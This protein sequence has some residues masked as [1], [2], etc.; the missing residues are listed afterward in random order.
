MTSPSANAAFRRM[1]DMYFADVLA[2]CLRRAST[3]DAK[4]AVADVFL[5]A[6][7]RFDDM[8]NGERVLPWLYGTARRVLANQRRSRSRFARLTDR[9]RSTA[10]EP[11]HVPTPETI[12]VRNQRSQEV[13]DALEHLRPDDR[14]VV[15]LVMWE[16]LPHAAVGEVL[17]CSDRAVTMRLHRAV[18][19]LRSELHTSDNGSLDVSSGTEAADE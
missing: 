7:R 1:Y 6:W 16:G 11:E 18:G 3:E 8:P 13:L 19:R 9:L 15:R 4:D 14:E 2:Y 5:V 12:V 17:G 10:P